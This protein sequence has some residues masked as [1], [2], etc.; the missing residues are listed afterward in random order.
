MSSGNNIVAQ[1]TLNRYY[2]DATGAT[3]QLNTIR[4]ITTIAIIFALVSVIGSAIGFNYDFKLFMP[5][6]SSATAV[7]LAA[8]MEGLRM[9]GVFGFF[10]FKDGHLKM[11]FASIIIVMTIFAIVLHIRGMQSMAVVEVKES[12][13]E[14]LRQNH[15]IDMMN[16]NRADSMMKLSAD[17]AKSVLSNGTRYDDTIAVKTMK[18]NNQLISQMVQSKRITPIQSKYL[19]SQRTQAEVVQKVMSIVL[20][21]I[22]IFA[23]LGFLAAYLKTRAVAEPV[24]DV[25]DT[26]QFYQALEANHLDLEDGVK[27]KMAEQ[28]QYANQAKEKIAAQYRENTGATIAS[29]ESA[30]RDTSNH[31]KEPILIGQNF[32]KK[33]PPK[34]QND[35]CEAEIVSEETISATNEK[36]KAI[37]PAVFGKQI[38]KVLVKL[39]WD[40]GNVKVG[41]PLIIRKYVVADAKEEG[42]KNAGEAYT[43]LMGELHDAGYIDHQPPKGY[44]AKVDLFR[45]VW[46][47]KS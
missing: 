19:E 3:A 13:S 31:Q 2:R 36:V 15:E 39:A 23:V 16:Q 24:K 41:D 21:L 43:I 5:D 18:Q 9:A 8:G 37:D 33:E 44:F 1:Q 35:E 38:N 17:T 40:N 29:R 26:H 4:I 32:K 47:D 46:V 6:Y 14:V 25:I 45:E 10:S 11:I 22:E 7:V 20:P 34:L 12:I 28:Q 27:Q 30:Y 42:F